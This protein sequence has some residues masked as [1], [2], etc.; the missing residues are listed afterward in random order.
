ME[1]KVIDEL[2][3][4][5]EVSEKPGQGFKYVRTRL[6]LDRL[7]KAFSNNWG[8]KIISQEIVGEEVVVLVRLDIYNNNG[9]VLASQEGFGSAK[10]FKNVELGN[11]YKS[12]TSRAIK[13]AAR[14]WGVG[15]FLEDDFNE[16]SEPSERNTKSSVPS[17]G[18]SSFTSGMP[19]TLK[20]TNS[21]MPSMSSTPKEET[22]TGSFPSSGSTTSM[23][24]TPTTSIPSLMPQLGMVTTPTVN[25]NEPLTMIQKVAITT[26]LTNKGLSFDEVKQEFYSNRGCEAPVDLDQ[27]RYKDALDMVTF[28]NSK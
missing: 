22:K 23:P 1:Q 20:S 21:S 2:Y 24:G 26:R 8:T 17:L 6:V 10:K 7:N 4:P 9:E 27:M 25:E 14:N 28:L 12:A 15:L 5:L 3:K 11:V 16:E 18:E 19:G 13:S